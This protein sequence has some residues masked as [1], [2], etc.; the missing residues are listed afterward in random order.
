M[1]ESV[2]EANMDDESLLSRIVRDPRV[3]AG[4]PVVVGTRLS[5]E[6]I[7]NLLAHG[8]SEEEILREYEGLKHEDILA[9]LLYAA[10]CLSEA[11]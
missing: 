10:R 6:F 5:V 9:C 2:K 1:L 3:L 11:A 8:S 4:K 7:V